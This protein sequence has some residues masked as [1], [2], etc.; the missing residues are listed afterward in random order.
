MTYDVQRLHPCS[1]FTQG[2]LRCTRRFRQCT[3][4][5]CS[6]RFV[7]GELRG[8]GAGDVSTCQ[9]HSITPLPSLKLACQLHSITPLP[10]L[11]QACQLH[12]ITPLPSLKQAFSAEAKCKR[13]WDTQC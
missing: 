6:L 11:K 12:S 3:S 9:L 10:S 8:E 7:R 5:L 4:A 13:W 2:R 1:L